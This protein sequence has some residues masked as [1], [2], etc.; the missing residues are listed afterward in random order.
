MRKFSFLA[1]LSALL[2]AA[3]GGGAQ[4]G[5]GTG[6]TG[7]GS[8]SSSSG[9]TG[10]AT[11]SALVAVS[12]L[13]TLPT[14]GS[15]TA[16]ITVYATD[17]T[18]QLLS[19][20]VVTFSASS[21]GVEVTRGTTDA[22]GTATAILNTA[23]NTTARTITVTATA[24][25]ITATV[26]VAVT[27]A[28]T[29]TTVPTGLVATAS[30]AT[31]PSDASATSVITV[32][33]TDAS[34]NL[35]SGVPVIFSASSGILT[36]TQATTTT[37]GAAT[38]TLS[39]AGN[40]T[41]RNIT[42]TATAGGKTATVVVQVVPSSVTS[43]T[44]A[45]LI[46]VSS[47]PTIPNDGTAT[48]TITV[49]AT[50]SS[51]NLIPG[52]TVK[53]AASSGVLTVTQAATSATGGA[54]A[55]LSTAGNPMV[56]TVTVTVTA[57]TATA[58][59]PVA[60]VQPGTTAVVPA[61]LIATASLPTIPADGSATSI[62]TAY[63]TDG[64][65]N[66]ISGVPLAFSADS[67]IIEVTQ[68]TTTATGAAT[69]TLSTAGNPT[70]RTI[71][72]T[73]TFGTGASAITTTVPVQVTA[74]GSGATPTKLTATTNLV[75]IPT[76]GTI[77]A[78]ITV[79]ATDASNSLIAGVPISFSASSGILA[80][81]QA[82]TTAAGG[83][84]AT[85]STA[86]NS[87]ARTI[88]VTATA[89]NGTVT[90]TVPVQV[91]GT[92][93][94]SVATLTAISSLATIPSDGSASAKITVLA[95]NATNNL[96]SGVPVTFLATSGGVAVIQG[97]T[98]AS[99]A[100]TA[101]LSTAGDSSLRTITVTATS[102]TGPTAV[103]TTINVPVVAPGT[104]TVTPVGLTAVSSVATIPSDGS[105]NATI[106]VYAFDGANNLLAGVPVAFSSTSGLVTVTQ[107]TT[108]AT[109]GAT[110]T[111]STAGNPALRTIT[112]TGAVGALKA[113]VNVPVVSATTSTTTLVKTLK[114][115]TS[116]PSIYNDGSTSA[117]ITALAL[118]ASNNVLAGVPISFVSSSGALV[119]AGTLTGPNG[120]LTATLTAGGDPTLRTITVT[121]S[122]TTL[123][124][125]VTVGVIQAP[126]APVYAL[127]N[128]TG[129]LFKTGAIALGSTNLSAGGTTSVSTTIVDQ[130]NTL[131][132]GGPVTVTF[133]S[134]C[135]A[136]N[137]AKI[138][139]A[140]SNVPV[141]AITTTTGIVSASY[142][143]TGCSGQDTIL[144]TATVA[145]QSLSATGAVTIAPASVGSIQFISATPTTIGLK[146]TGLSESSTVIFKV[147]DSSG[148]PIANQSV[149]FSLNTTVGGLS[150]APATG[151]SATD[152]T[153]QTVVASGTVHT[154]VRVT[155]VIAATSTTPQFSTES[156]ELTVTTGLPAANAFSIAIGAAS[157]GPKG[158]GC[159]NI[160][161]FGID[162]ITAP[163]TV[164]L[165]DRYNNPVP[166][167][168]AVAFTTDGGHIA[169]NCSTAAGDGSCSVTWTSANP[170]PG[171]NP[172]TNLTDLIFGYPAA[173]PPLK[174]AGRVVVLATTIGEESFNDVNGTGFFGGADTY[175][176]L[177]EPYEDDNEN[178]QY[179]VGEYFL[180]FNQDK[181]RNGPSGSFVGITCT[182]ITSSDTCSTSTLAI[183]ASHLIIMSTSGA[184][185][186]LDSLASG[187]TNG[188]T[189]ADT[190]T[191]ALSIV[192]G[193][194]GN[195]SLYVVDENG[196][197]MAAGTT[198][199]FTL[200]NGNIGAT[201]T[202]NAP[203]SFG[204]SGD[205]G[206]AHFSASLSTT[207]GTPGAGNIVV[208]VTSTSG[209]VSSVSLPLTITP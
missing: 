208:S 194:S 166:D 122:T 55:T 28:G 139:P 115:S 205:V 206:G 199:G 102:G 154:A 31:I 107:G 2:L 135:L 91:V 61:H 17:S 72:V 23:G 5:S 53:F 105:L 25:G 98:D 129:T 66:L 60:V 131:Y 29:T 172:L 174:A 46:A 94:T 79:Y 196:N 193:N 21:G 207:K 145:G 137:K 82:T 44:P 159:P 160:D 133:N 95:R 88:T 51:N 119:P 101:T 71:T 64:S 176:A 8:S 75:S 143:A 39:T 7:S 140:G 109:G 175:T 30:A 198:V 56:R 27:T 52:V 108:T 54:S 203:S 169:G 89:A 84:T 116:S 18:N 47:T 80:V 38:A 16:T 96:I 192:S 110:A 147:T 33:A 41:L 32:Y 181:T 152:G 128:G 73:V 180:D 153:V 22:T 179:D 63:A 168:T 173:Y 189:S 99:G 197:P 146:G 57:G 164:R 58:T 132:N 204:C 6:S 141:S 59:V 136:N 83:A 126:V 34:N 142:V 190:T 148:A 40:S 165:A 134:P 167:G 12:S 65:N 20:V 76:D 118:D 182:G 14:D 106:T 178:G 97:T 26:P 92:N 120:T 111:L 42:V 19:G 156:S 90:T 86:G 127:G 123:S 50:D 191:G 103:Q 113:T 1:C 49:L 62:I 3:C 100:A 144:A 151:I 202:Q 70:A 177:G 68:G 69:A 155:A 35:V 149:S 81:T 157:N 93:P 11:P 48:A 37:T 209:T 13:A 45:N 185:I 150:L 121:G 163:L 186:A 4:L 15:R 78:T 162:G 130:T 112:V 24:G 85:I 43:V 114:V 104:S 138:L 158:L 195:V 200:T 187:Y 201:L 170:R 171:F 74:A 67:G 184:Q 9:G 161:S 10:G 183:G 36:V 87:T 117:T 124:S 125:P 77:T 188:F